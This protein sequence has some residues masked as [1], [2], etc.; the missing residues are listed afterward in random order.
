MRREDPLETATRQ[1][2][3][4]TVHGDGTILYK[5]TP[6]VVCHDRLVIEGGATPTTWA[7]SQ[8][9][10]KGLVERVADE[11]FYSKTHQGFVC[12]HCVPRPVR[13][14][15]PVPSA[16][17]SDPAP[18][19]T[20]AA[21]PAT[22]GPREE[23]GRMVFEDGSWIA[24]RLYNAVKYSRA[25]R[26]GAGSTLG[27]VAGLIDRQATPADPSFVALPQ[28]ADEPAL[29]VHPAIVARVEGRLDPLPTAA[30]WTGGTLQVDEAPAPSPATPPGAHA[31]MMSAEEFARWSTSPE[32]EA[33]MQRVAGD[34]R[35]QV[36][37]AFEEFKGRHDELGQRLDGM[38]G[39]LDELAPKLDLVASHAPTA[40]ERLTAL[41]ARVEKLEHRRGGRKGS[42]SGENAS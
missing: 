20:P 30:P 38:Q 4:F 14:R 19:P 3:H 21:A 24:S 25:G 39:R 7:K 34:M 28:E 11:G 15:K 42:D 6:C 5:L 23:G 10:A 8:V 32:F 13:E 26:V 27:A 1:F 31:P 18:A 33:L 2:T 16:A 17:S 12:T 40:L 41:E 37:E 29:W 9:L 22:D 36:L 35:D